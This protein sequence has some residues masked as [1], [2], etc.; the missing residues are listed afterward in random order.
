VKVTF[1]VA[2]VE[3]L[4]S[5]VKDNDV[6]LPVLIIGK[7]LVISASNGTDDPE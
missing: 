5:I 3:V 1:T 7:L 2:K 4:V 6:N